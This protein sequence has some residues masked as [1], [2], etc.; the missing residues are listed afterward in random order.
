MNGAAIECRNITKHFGKGET[1][2][3]ALN[4]INCTSSDLI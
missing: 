1:R 3:V 4:G 2:V